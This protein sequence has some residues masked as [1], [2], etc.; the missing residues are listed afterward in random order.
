MEFLKNRFNRNP[1]ASVLLIALV[2]RLLS[3]L[4]SQ[5]YGMHDDHFIIIETSKSWVMG[6]DFNYWLPQNQQHPQAAGHNLL[7]IGIHYF[8][9]LLFKGLGI[10][11]PQVQMMLIRIIHALYSLLIVFYGYKIAEKLSGQKVAIQVGLMLALLWF[12]PFMSIRNLVE[13]VAI[14]IL[15]G[16]T[17]MLVKTEKPLL[18]TFFLAGLV[19]SIAVSVRYQT[20]IYIG[21]IGL[22]LLLQKKIKEALVF[23]FGSI[24]SI[25]VIQG[26][27]DLYIWGKPFEEMKQYILYNIIYRN[28]YGTNN[29]LMY[30]EV[31]LGFL[32]PP[33]SLFLFFGFFK[34]WKK[35][36]LLFLPTFLFLAFHTYFPNKQERFIFTI[37]PF[38][39]VLGWIGWH[40][41]LESSQYWKARPKLL[42]GCYTAFWIINLSIL[43]FI[44]LSSSKISRVNAMYALYPDIKNIKAVLVEDSERFPTVMLPVFYSGGTPMVYSLEKTDKPDPYFINNENA[45]IKPINTLDFFKVNPIAIQPQYVIF[46]EGKNLDARIAKVKEY[47]PG[48]SFIKKIEPSNVDRIM[49]TL[50]PNNKN[51][52]FYLYK[53]EG[54]AVS[55]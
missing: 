17:W 16:G 32:I 6:N 42:K 3:A 39:V 38:I 23:G 35:H 19:M 9:F 49:K 52:V 51:E 45:Y 44:S 37:V 13:I 7:Y 48:L 5:G 20:F 21:G 25:A 55:K 11:N 4:F 41:F 28:A 53:T 26:G 2:I 50:N 12:L 24:I 22:A 15:M 54:V 33:V 1:L 18:K 8:L 27:I 10:N 34:V 40:E 29:Y 14:P 43:P 36:L 31:I 30:F 47:F 46:N